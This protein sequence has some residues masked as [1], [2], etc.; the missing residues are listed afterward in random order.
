M[1]LIGF[2]NSAKSFT[3]PKPNDITFFMLAK[4]SSD[5]ADVHIHVLMLTGAL[6]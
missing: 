2:T 4:A 3:V 1:G 6:F 5:G